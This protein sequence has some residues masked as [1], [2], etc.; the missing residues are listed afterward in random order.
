MPHIA[1]DDGLRLQPQTLRL[2]ADHTDR[3]Q[4]R[5]SAFP[6]ATLNVSSEAVLADEATTADLG[7]AYRRWQTALTVLRGDGQHIAALLRDYAEDTTT[8]DHD[9]ASTFTTPTPT[10][11]PTP[12]DHQLDA[13]HRDVNHRDVNHAG[14]ADVASWPAGE[15][16]AGARVEARRG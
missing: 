7:V 15:H 11:T 1:P 3:L 2:A 12:T 16:H 4:Q 8:I 5:L 13:N 14:V 10:P 6:V 9:T